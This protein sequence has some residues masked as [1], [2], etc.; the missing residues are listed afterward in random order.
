MASAGIAGVAI[1]FGAQSL[2]KDFLAGMF[3][4]VEDQ[5]GVG[6]VIDVG[7]MAARRWPA[8][9]RRCPCGPPG[10]GTS[11]G[12][13]WYVPNGR[14]SGSATR[15][16][17]GP[18]R[19]STSSVGYERRPG[20]A[21]DVIKE[22]A[23]GLWQDRTGPASARG[24]RGLGRRGLA[25]EGVTIQVIVQTLPD[26]G[27][28][29]SASSAA[30]MKRALDDAG[31]PPPLLPG[32]LVGTA[33]DTTH[34]ERE[35]RRQAL[36]GVRRRGRVTSTA[37][38]S[39]FAEKSWS[40]RR[41]PGRRGDLVQG[42]QALGRVGHLDLRD[43][44][45]HRPLGLGLRSPDLGEDLGGDVERRADRRR[46]PPRAGHRPTARPSGGCE[47]SCH[48]DHTSS[49]TYG[50]NGAKSLR[51]V[52]RASPRAALADSAPGSS[53]RRRGS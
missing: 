50:R 16:S 32:A 20:A 22:V 24:A 45:A 28:R 27:S 37:K 19:C 21:Q 23:D 4:L 53:L 42:S 29:C 39:P 25:P 40:T 8:R 18:E 7:E 12:T 48:H 11:N 1:G 44:G 3:I 2:V 17:S 41:R 49:V 46:R 6:D 52:S 5:Y 34:P 38:T 10:C 30:V 26:A 47:P 31:V 13:V 9:S 35:A 15:A 51:S 33:T 14:S 43:L 36:T